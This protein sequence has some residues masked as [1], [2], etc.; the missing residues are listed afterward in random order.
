MKFPFRRNLND[1]AKRLQLESKSLTS[2]SCQSDT[3]YRYL[4]GDQKEERPL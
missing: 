3:N 1:V 4:G 2:F